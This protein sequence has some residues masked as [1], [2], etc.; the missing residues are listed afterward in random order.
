MPN[1]QSVKN[2]EETHNKVRNAKAH[3]TVA[4]AGTRTIHIAAI[5]LGFLPLLIAC[6]YGGYVFATTDSGIFRTALE[7]TGK[8]V[9]II[10]GILVALVCAAEAGLLAG[11]IV[12]V[13]VYALIAWVFVLIVPAVPWILIAI[14]ALVLWVGAVQLFKKIYLSRKPVDNYGTMDLN[15]AAAYAEIGA[16]F[17]SRNKLLPGMHPEYPAIVYKDNASNARKG[18]GQMALK[19][20]SILLLA[21]L[22]FAGSAWFRSY[23]TGKASAKSQAMVMYNGTYTG[24]FDDR[25]STM[26]LTTDTIDGK[27]VVTGEMTI[28]YR[29]PLNHQLKGTL[30]PEHPEKL[31]LNV[32]KADGTVDRYIT[33]T[34]G[35]A[36]D[37]DDTIEGS[38]ANNHKGSSY[39]Y[40]L[41]K[42]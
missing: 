10:I 8:W 16:A 20:F 36:K 29:H 15:D 18:R 38:Y 31:K 35:K 23:A 12:G 2:A 34:I 40:R 39:T 3:F 13:I 22:I 9:G 42:K 30:D 5:V 11:G 28:N 6:I 37:A 26:T 19:G 17:G 21:V 4:R 27:Y 41:T 14:L 25:N 33:Y 1:A 7:S 32:V 24:Q